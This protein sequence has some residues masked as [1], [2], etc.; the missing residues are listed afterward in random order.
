M[1]P[2]SLFVAFLWALGGIL[3][4]YSLRTL[5]PKMLFIIG[6]AL[7]S[8]LVIAYGAI[9]RKEVLASFPK[10]DT[11]TWASIIGF[12][13][14]SMFLSIIL[15]YNLLES[16]DAYKVNTITYVAPLFTLILAII[17]LGE[18][19]TIHAA[20]GVGLVVAGIYMIATHCD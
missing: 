8:V 11:P 17:F 3:Q 10:I 15:F 18:R 6:G 12:V 2:Q 13:T 16:N 4:K 14:L 19:P 9:H 20:L 7:F 5:S 1:V